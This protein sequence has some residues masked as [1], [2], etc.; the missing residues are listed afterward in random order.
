M[1]VVT[2]GT[3]T[4]VPDPDRASA[5]LWIEVPDARIILDCGAG[6]LQGMARAG[7]GW[8]DVT[9]LVLSHFHN[10]HLNDVPALFF[11]LRYGLAVPRTRPLQ[12]LGPVGVQRLFERW[13]RALGDWL[14]EPG[15]PLTITALGPEEVSPVGAGTL[16]AHPTPHTDESLA[17]RLEA[18][19]GTLG[20]TGDT[21]ESAE[22]ADFLAGV[23]LLVA[24]CSLP[25]DQ[26]ID[27]HLTPARV[28][29]MA[30]RARPGRLVLTHV[31]PQLRGEDLAARI[32]A[33]GYAGPVVHAH[34]G[35]EFRLDAPMNAS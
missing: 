19:G 6:A 26:A 35:M 28:A 27:H 4:V 3:G 16:R 18:P 2:V 33:A 22:V 34:D 5:C 13:A 21:G 11:A 1:R 17:Y 25:D 29:R 10:D 15:F 23:D 12:V 31:Y 7:L 9:H 20:Y 32:R 24:E 30:A 8:G 14:I